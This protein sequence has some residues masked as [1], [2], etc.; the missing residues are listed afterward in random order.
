MRRRAGGRPP[1]KAFAQGCERPQWV[2]R[3]T[4]RLFIVFYIRLPGCAVVGSGV[5]PVNA[6][7]VAGLGAA[8]ARASDGIDWDRVDGAVHAH[9]VLSGS[10]RADIWRCTVQ[11][12]V[13]VAD[14]VR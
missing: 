6:S 13:V 3:P 11:N 14:L 4:G 1:S 9:C 10:W 7:A 12:G 2:P 5:T 8:V